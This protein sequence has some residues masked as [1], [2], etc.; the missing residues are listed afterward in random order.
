MGVYQVIGVCLQDLGL[1]Q[2]LLPCLSRYCGIKSVPKITWDCAGYVFRRDSVNSYSALV[3]IHLKRFLQTIMAKKSSSPRKLVDRSVPSGLESCWKLWRL[4]LCRNGFYPLV[5]APFV[6]AAW[7]LDL[8]G[9]MGCNSLHLEVGMEPLN[10]AWNKTSMDLGL[11]HF[12]SDEMDDMSQNNDFLMNALHPECQ[13][14]DSLFNEYFIDG[15][16]TWKM[17]QYMAYIS[18]SAGCIATVSSINS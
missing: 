18:G 11:F 13:R 10:T 3:L 8:Y 7:L 12:R 6:T 4:C 14:Y 9:T 15:D 2:L 17:S 5:V 16:K 1:Y